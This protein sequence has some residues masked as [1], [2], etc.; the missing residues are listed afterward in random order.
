MSV[1]LARPGTIATIIAAGS[2]AVGDDSGNLKIHVQQYQDRFRVVANEVTGDGH[3]SPH[4][5]HGGLLYGEFRLTG[6]MVAAHA[7]GIANLKADSNGGYAATLPHTMTINFD[8][9]RLVH[10]QILI[11]D[12]QRQFAKNQPHVQVSLSGVFT[13]VDPSETA[14]S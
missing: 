14:P 9:Q 6:L 13:R 4:F 3:T 8:S 12:V 10:G 7:V 1:A 11:T 5:Q 2:T